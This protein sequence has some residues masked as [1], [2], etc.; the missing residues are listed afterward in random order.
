MTIAVLTDVHGN[1]LALNAVI[2]DALASG[3][4]RWW[5]LGDLVAMGPDPVGTVARLRDLDAEVRIL[6]NTDR[7]VLDDSSPFPP[8][9]ELEL[10]STLVDQ[11][12]MIAA[13]LAWT[14][15]ALTTSGDLD[16]LAD[17]ATAHRATLADGAD[18]LAV[19]ASAMRD[20]GPGITSDISD[21]ELRG[22]FARETARLIVGGHTHRVTDRTIEGQ[23]FLNPGS[24]SNHM[25][26]DRRT[27][28][29]L[30][31]DDPAGHRIELR[32]FE[33]DVNSALAMLAASGVPGSDWIIERYFPGSSPVLS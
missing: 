18:V 21:H 28:Y 12:T 15:G 4:R 22:L 14:K 2:A 31:H 33:Y 17:A 13:S 9:E 29:A 32:A 24:V 30:I 7:Y 8:S 27:R 11:M 23:R 26:E 10:T 3:A 6:G 16:W 1:S 5:L 25:S 19:H 20:D